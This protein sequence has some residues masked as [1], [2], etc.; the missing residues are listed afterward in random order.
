MAP[1]RSPRWPA[2][3]VGSITH[4]E[5]FVGAV[6][7]SARSTGGIGF[8]VE[9]AVPLVA[10]LGLRICTPE[11]LAWARAAP[12]LVAGNWEKIF[13]SAKEAIH[14]VVSPLS[15]ITLGFR[16]VTVVCDR[17]SGTFRARLTEPRSGLPDF[18]RIVG[19][20]AVTEGLVMTS[21]FL[22]GGSGTG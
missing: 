7:A 14:K 10:D 4:C 15:G 19:R 12:P 21:A 6:V 8:D 18:R 13:F 5:G 17:T 2:G 11:E 20:F 9:P 16:D 3:V 1:N 22:E